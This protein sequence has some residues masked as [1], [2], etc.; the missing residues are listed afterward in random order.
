MKWLFFINLAIHFAQSLNAQECQENFNKGEMCRSKGQYEKAIG[1]YTKSQNCGDVN[2]KTKSR[3][4]ISDVNRLI[5]E[6]DAV[7][8]SPSSKR[9]EYIIVPTLIYLPN[10][11]DEQTVIVESSGDW[12]IRGKSNIINVAKKN[13][14]TLTVSS[15]SENTST[16]PRRSSVTVECG[17]VT[18][19]ITIEQDGVPEVLEYIS[20][21][22]NV[23][24]TGGRFVIELN[25]NTKWKVDY[26]D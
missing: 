18:R 23:P 8:N 5:R 26:A 9:T 16:K 13:S 3:A 22:M 1:Y 24:Y 25:T 11:T 20:K 6:R 21:Y 17:E 15:V 7:K 10:G 19:T 2:Y 12:G 4:M 14:K